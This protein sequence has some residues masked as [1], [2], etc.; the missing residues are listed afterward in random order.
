MPTTLDL[1]LLRS[2]VMVADRKSVSRAAQHLHRVQ[3]AVSQQIQKLELQVGAPLFERTKS[4]FALT[5]LGEVLYPM[6]LKLL[7]LNDEIVERVNRKHQKNV[8]VIGTSDVYAHNHVAQ[9]L[10]S[11]NGKFGHVRT[12]LV[13]AYSSTIWRHLA[14]GRI[15]IAI[16]QSRP[17]SVPGEILFVEPLV[18]V[19]ARHYT[20]HQ[21]RPL[22]LALFGQGCA[23]RTAAIR[24]LTSA[25]I[26]YDIL[27]VSDHFSGVIAPVKVGIA[28]S[29][30]P[31]SVVDPSIRILNPSDGL[32]ELG[33][34]QIS[35]SKKPGSSAEDIAGFCE[36][37]RTYFTSDTMGVHSVN[38]AG[39]H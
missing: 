23:D 15:D 21:L 13:C 12:E 2:F 30:L 4:G 10:R 34:I 20:P 1:K 6:A 22:P 17:D 9:I 25:N 18:W 39:A 36:A 28:V 5:P 24:S 29:V 37:A 7:D 16:T 14:E 11:Y 26:P 33:T 8:V 27:S 32:P 31:L 3:S 19:G 38:K 35:I